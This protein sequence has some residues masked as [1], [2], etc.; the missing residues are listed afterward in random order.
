[1]L[2]Y[3]LNIPLRQLQ[4]IAIYFNLTGFETFS[5]NRLIEFLI[6]NVNNRALQ[7]YIQPLIDEDNYL[8]KRIETEL[9]QQEIEEQLGQMGFNQRLQQQPIATGYSQPIGTI[10]VSSQTLNSLL[11]GMS[12]GSPVNSRMIKMRVG[13]NR[14][15][16]RLYR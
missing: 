12:I 2:D 14:P 1:M 10:H 9:I 4:N 6:S 3:L 15:I 16:K 5:K 11:N 8:G 13:K 7:Q